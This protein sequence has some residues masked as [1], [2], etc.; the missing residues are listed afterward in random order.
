M[1][2]EGPLDAGIIGKNSEPAM[3]KNNLNTNNSSDKMITY[4]N[5]KLMKNENDS[6]S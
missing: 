6:V 2:F 1:T 5:I 3:F 4:N